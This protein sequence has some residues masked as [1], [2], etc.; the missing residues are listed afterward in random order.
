MECEFCFDNPKEAT[1]IAYQYTSKGVRRL[2]K[3][4]GYNVE[5]ILH[6]CDECAEVLLEMYE[7][8]EWENAHPTTSIE[9]ADSE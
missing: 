3:S 1:Q 9:P 4:V 7:W 6:V 8:A 5:D 2:M